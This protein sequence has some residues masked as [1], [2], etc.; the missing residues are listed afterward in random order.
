MFDEL[1]VKV[2]PQFYS[3]YVGAIDLIANIL[4][5]YKAR[6]VLIVHGEVSWEKARSK[7]SFLEVETQ[8]FFYYQYGGECSYYET[9]RVQEVVKNSNVD[10][11]I[12]VGGGK[13]ADLVGYVANLQNVNFGMIPTLASNCA[14]WTPL[15]VMYKETGAAEGKTEH[16]LQQAVFL[17]TD[18]VIIIDA[19]A[20]YFIAGLADTL[21]KWY[22]SESILKQAH[23]QHKPFLHLASC[24]AKLCKDA[25]TQYA[26]KALADMEKGQLSTEFI[27]L[28]EIVFAISG[29]VGGFGDKY[30]R[31]AAAHAMHDA[32]SKYI[33][34]CHH[35]LHGEKVA[36]G[37]FYQLALEKRWSE[38]EQLLPLYKEL[39]LPVSLRQMGIFPQDEKVIN[40]IVRFIEAQAK[41]HLIPV[42]ITQE[43]L[44]E[45]IYSLEDYID[46]IYGGDIWKL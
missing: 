11:I 42:S 24:T 38:I 35:F 14:A 40:Q 45:T 15:S 29:L 27:Y 26:T 33:P 6:R 16:Y 4:Q 2:G 46:N 8:T 30:A 32:M 13:L 37:I 20:E 1:K 43:I 23:L 18:P 9:K 36:Y 19:P 39:N 5:E 10:F 22:E 25:I 12:G 3:Y 31:N 28:S 34:D 44:K 17:I 7:L 21:A 41:V